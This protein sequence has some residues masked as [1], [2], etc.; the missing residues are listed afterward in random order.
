MWGEGS[1]TEVGLEDESKHGPEDE[2]KGDRPFG[3]GVHGVHGGQGGV[4]RMASGRLTGQ[5]P[6][7]AGEDAKMNK[8]I[9]IVGSYGWARDMV[10]KWGIDGALQKAHN[11]WLQSKSGRRSSVGQG[12]HGGG[13]SHGGGGQGGHGGGGHGGGGHGGGGHGG[14]GGGG[15]HGVHGGDGGFGSHGGGGGGGV[16]GVHGG[17]RARRRLTGQSHSAAEDHEK[18]HERSG[19]MGSDDLAHGL[20]DQV[21]IKAQNWPDGMSGHGGGGGGG[22]H[23]GRTSDQDEVETDKIEKSILE[24]VIKMSENEQALARTSSEQL[25]KEIELINKRTRALERGRLKN[26]LHALRKKILRVLRI[27]QRARGNNRLYEIELEFI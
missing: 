16:H 24:K 23:G 5:S 6:T 7:E 21:G 26:A 9:G 18:F 4:H 15:V 27:R 10:A 2:T 8:L 19:I 14:G 12:G 11:I 17:W 13:S 3:H 20:V 1:H 22:D 25:R